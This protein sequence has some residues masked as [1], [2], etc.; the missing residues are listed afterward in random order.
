MLAGKELAGALSLCPE[1]IKPDPTALLLQLTGLDSTF[2]AMVSHSASVISLQPVQPDVLGAYA[3]AVF[4]SMLVIGLP[5][6]TETTA[7]ELADV[8]AVTLF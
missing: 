6:A 7:R 8:Q 4:W 5:E 3:D 2:W 1:Y